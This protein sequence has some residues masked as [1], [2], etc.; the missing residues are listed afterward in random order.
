MK[1]KYHL[2]IAFGIIIIALFLTSVASATAV[3]AFGIDKESTTT[4]WNLMW[5]NLFT[6][7]PTDDTLETLMAAPFGLPE[8]MANDLIEEH[9]TGNSLL[10]GIL[11][12]IPV[13]AVI[14]GLVLVAL[15]D[16]VQKYLYV[17][18]GLIFV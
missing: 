10:S 4:I 11:G 6:N 3:P 1:L 18:F 16:N 9:G 13:L 17:V 8:T 2:L 7:I 5:E 15:K 14:G 12:L